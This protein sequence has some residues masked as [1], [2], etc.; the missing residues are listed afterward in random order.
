MTFV[1]M[2]AAR[3]YTPAVLFTLAA[4]A[5][6]M[7]AGWLF[8]RDGWAVAGPATMPA[9][10][11]ISIAFAFG[12]RAGGADLPREQRTKPHI[13]NRIRHYAVLLAGLP[14]AGSGASTITSIAVLVVS[15]LAGLAMQVAGYAMAKWALVFVPPL[16][17]VAVATIT[18]AFVI[19]QRA[20]RSTRTKPA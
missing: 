20:N 1:D 2:R 15:L 17:L 14:S 11:L 13:R 12:Q 3:W 8:A 5:V 10:P 19:I 7:L 18:S 4:G 6:M 9:G 16:L